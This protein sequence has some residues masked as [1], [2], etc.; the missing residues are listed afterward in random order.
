MSYYSLCNHLAK[1]SRQAQLLAK[2]TVSP[3]SKAFNL[4]LII[5]P[6]SSSSL[7]R[8][9]CSF[10]IYH[11]KNQNHHLSSPQLNRRLKS[12]IFHN[13][14]LFNSQPY[15]SSSTTSTPAASQKSPSSESDSDADELSIEEY[16]RL[17][18]MY[19]DTLVSILE[20]LQEERADVD[21]EFSA[22]VLTLYFPPHGTYVLNK[23]P[24]NK[25]IWLSS[26]VS[27]PKRYDYV[28]IKGDREG[29]WIYG[30]DGS[31]LSELL[32]RELGLGS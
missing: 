24:P 22:G 1:L 13:H 5:L 31:R 29:D 9:C 18:N 7:F 16:H 30:R 25:Q 12:S 3:H 8:G 15:S 10:S 21:C 2:P 20:Q 14:H 19:I 26:P 32:K 27:G 6:P 4:G 11:N 28:K 17:S 23:Q